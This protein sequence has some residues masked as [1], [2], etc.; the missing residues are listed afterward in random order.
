MG[1]SAGYEHSGCNNRLFMEAV[2]WIARTSSP[3]RDL[4]AMFDNRST[5][6]RRSS[7]WHKTDVFER[8]F[9]AFSDEPGMEY[10]MVNATIIK[11]HRHSQA[12]KSVLEPDHRPLQMRYDNQAA[13]PDRCAGNLDRIHLMP[14]RRFDTARVAPLINGI[15]FGAQLVDKSF[16]G[17]HIGAE[18]NERGAKIVISQHPRRSKPVPREARNVRMA[19]FDR[20]LLLRA[21]RVQAYRH[22][23]LQ[24][25]Y[26][27]RSRHHQ[28]TMVS[29]G[30]GAGQ[31]IIPKKGTRPGRLPYHEFLSTTSAC[32][33]PSPT[34]RAFSRSFARCAATAASPFPRPRQRPRKRRSNSSSGT[35]R[36][37]V[38]S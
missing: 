28:F 23:D 15:E 19:A 18:L 32:R 8:I 36:N 14:G 20:K 5:P 9:D 29:T 37:S 24:S 7:D 17:N 16:D 31:K 2:P 26:P 11:V 35:S 34:T 25:H 4:P 21:Q 22:A 38:R 13:G 6:L 3:R 1:R 30:L 10:A 12:Q 27:S 33:E